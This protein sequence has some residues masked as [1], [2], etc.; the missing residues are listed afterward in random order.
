M[1]LGSLALCWDDLPPHPHTYTTPRAGLTAIHFT[2]DKA[3]APSGAS[4]MQVCLT[5]K[6][7]LLTTTPMAGKQKTVWSLFDF[8]PSHLPAFV[9]AVFP[10]YHVFL[11]F[12]QILP[13]PKACLLQEVLLDI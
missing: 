8:S 6:S 3:E 1:S 11:S 7:K 12:M 4:Y 10:S 9:H 2:A 13:S 5:L